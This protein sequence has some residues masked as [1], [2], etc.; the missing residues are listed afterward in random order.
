LELRRASR[1]FFVDTSGCELEALENPY[2]YLLTHA[3]PTGPEL[4]TIVT[5]GRPLLEPQRVHAPLPD[6]DRVFLD[7]DGHIYARIENTIFCAR[8]PQITSSGTLR[9][10][11]CYDRSTLE[12]QTTSAN[13]FEAGLNLGHYVMATLS[14]GLGI[15]FLFQKLMGRKER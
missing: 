9:M 5:H 8:P 7:G 3:S 13:H 4:T 14:L 10:N 6:V 12:N 11:D 1:G 2:R 15:V